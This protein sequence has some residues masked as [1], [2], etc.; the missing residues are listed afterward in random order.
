M[1]SNKEVARRFYEEVFNKH[2]VDM[3]DELVAPDYNEHDPLP[4]QRAGLDGVRDRVTMII[5]VS[6]R[7]SPARM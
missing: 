3:L 2:D 1:E 7:I 5:D 4:G 6:I